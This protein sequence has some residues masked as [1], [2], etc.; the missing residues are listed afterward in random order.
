VELD[1]LRYKQNLNAILNVVITT[2]RTLAPTLSFLVFA[3]TQREPLSASTA[4]SCLAWYN[5]LRRPLAYLP[6]AVTSGLDASVSIG[7]LTHL[8]NENVGDAALVPS[9]SL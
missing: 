5:L 6:Y 7:R 1:A 9:V 4:F 3:Y 8:F 2:G